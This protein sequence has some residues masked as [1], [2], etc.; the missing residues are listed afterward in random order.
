VTVIKRHPRKKK[1]IFLTSLFKQADML[2]ENTQYEN[3]VKN[4][5]RSTGHRRREGN[6]AKTG[7]EAASQN[8][9]S[10]Q[11]YNNEVILSLRKIRVFY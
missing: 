3:C 7:K 1:Q 9:K 2:A 10:K 4:S 6:K 11:F 5:K 8:R